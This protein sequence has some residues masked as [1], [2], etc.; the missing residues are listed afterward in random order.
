[1]YLS[2]LLRSAPTWAACTLTA[3]FAVGATNAPIVVSFT[4]Y[5]TIIVEASRI[6]HTPDKMASGVTIIT[7]EQIKEAGVTDTIQALERLGGLYFRR[8]SGNPNQA[9][10]VMRGFSQNAHGRVL[11]LVDGQRL[12]DPDMAPPNWAR[13]PV[14]SIERIEILHGAETTL[15]G[16]YAVAGVINIITRKGTEPRTSLSVTAGS[17]DTF[18]THLHKSGF[19]DEETRYAADLDWQK[20]QGWRANSQYET[21]AAR[22][23]LEHDWTERLSSSLGT[24]YNWGDY[25]LPGALSRQQMRD[26][27]R[28][29]TTPLDNT[30]QETWGLSM[31]ATGETL[32]WGEFSLNLMAQRRLRQSEMASWFSAADTGI[33]SLSLQPKYQLEREV[34]GYLNLLTLGLDTS[35][36]RLD[37]KQ[38]TFP[39]GLHVADASLDRFDGSFYALD[40][41]FFTDELS[42]T[43][44]GRGACMRTSLSG[45]SSG[46]R[47]QGSAHDWESAFNGAL[48]YRPTKDQKYFIRLSTLYRYPFLDEI[49]SYQGWGPGF[50]PD[51]EAEK[52]WQLEAGL[53]VTLLEQVSYELRV[54]QLSLRDEIAW[55]GTRNENLDETRRTGLE[56]SLTWTP[57]RWGSLGLNYHLL[58]AEFAEGVNEGNHIPLAPAQVVT[59][60]GTVN[61]AY[62]LSLLAATRAVSS[63]YVGDDNANASE[64]IEGFFTCDAGARYTPTFFKDLSVLVSC[65]NLFDTHYA[66]SG[67]WGWGF[68]DHYYPANGRTWRLSASYSF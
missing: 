60:Q 39:A 45:D 14:E 52:G 63:Q 66:T 48:L 40:E 67:Y 20:S 61:V 57:K 68:G 31:G 17:E 23:S 1:M 33:N 49:A 42:L 8:E 53:S 18:C 44:G 51:L 22:T 56:T 2:T 59:L 7:S 55:N 34:G 24:F 19:F 12:N 54:Y 29:T 65:D 30:R 36:E 37:Y 21:Y 9:E 28:Q 16:N 62:G 32:E 41:F 10:I 50:N 27:P 3:S 47:L 58:Q 11:V 4:N 46:T 13:I 64:R 25:G 15:H 43:L 6:G 35:F 26:D 5:P 38:R